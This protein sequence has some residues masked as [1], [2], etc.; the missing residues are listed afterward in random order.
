M[1]GFI[2]LLNNIDSITQ[3]KYSLIIRVSVIT[4]IDRYP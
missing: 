2:I 1:F 4:L 3:D